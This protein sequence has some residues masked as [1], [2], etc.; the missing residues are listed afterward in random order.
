MTGARAKVVAGGLDKLEGLRSRRNRNASA[1][2]DEL[3]RIADD[4]DRQAA[5]ADAPDAKRL[6][7]VAE[8]LR[9][10]IAAAG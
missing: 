8:I 9:A 5:S 1:L 2:I 4:L 3:T 7:G 6:R 10:R